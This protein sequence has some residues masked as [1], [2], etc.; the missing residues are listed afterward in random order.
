MVIQDDGKVGI[1]ASTPVSNLHVKDDSGEAKLI[2]QAGSNT[3]SAILQFGDSIDV[4]RGG[5]EYTSTDDMVFS[6]NNFST[7]MTIRYTGNVGIGVTPPLIV[8]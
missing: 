2:I 7:A 1:G 3:N 5:I 6:T 4:S 8:V